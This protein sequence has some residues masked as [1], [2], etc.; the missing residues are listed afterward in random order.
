MLEPPTRQQHAGVDQRLDHRIVGVTLSAG[1][2]EYALAGKA[3]C[4]VSERAVLIDR[5]R[6]HRVDAAR[7]QCTRVRGP[8]LEVFATMARRGVHKP[9]AGIFCNV[10]AGQQRHSERIV[11]GKAFERVR[12]D[13][14]LQRRR[15]DGRPPFIGDDTGLRHHVR[16]KSVG[17][18]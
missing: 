2:G 12:T 8:D 9:G 3:R 6:N 1:V 5:V 16:S 17:Q 10:V 7:R 14:P 13:E 11:V 4:M 15:I 18:Q